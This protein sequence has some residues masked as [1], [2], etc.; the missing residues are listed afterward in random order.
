[1][2]ELPANLWMNNDLTPDEFATL[3]ALSGPQGDHG[4]SVRLASNFDDMR[5]RTF[6]ELFGSVLDDLEASDPE[7]P[8][9]HQELT[10]LLSSQNP[11][12]RAL[13]VRLA[14]RVE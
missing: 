2:V 5:S 3:W 8:P 14:G 10:V 11:R 6:A 13:G 1:V 4:T 12:V 9:T 7:R